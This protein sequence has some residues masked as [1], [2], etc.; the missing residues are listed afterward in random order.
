[1]RSRPFLGESAGGGRGVLVHEDRPIHLRHRDTPAIKAREGG[2]VIN[3]A[4]LLA[5]GVNADGHREILGLDV[6]TPEDGA[7]WLAFFRNLTARGVSGVR[8]VTSDAHKAS[9]PRSARRCPARRGSGAGRT[10]P[11]T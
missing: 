9:W 8:L 3:V 4:A 1:M 7:G 5:V 6:S 2:R 10:T 11:R